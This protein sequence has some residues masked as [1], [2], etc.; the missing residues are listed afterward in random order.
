MGDTK[1]WCSS[2]MPSVPVCPAG[3]GKPEPNLPDI[4]WPRFQMGVQRG[5]SDVLW[6]NLESKSEAKTRVLCGRSFRSKQSPGGTRFFWDGFSQDSSTQ[7]PA[8]WESGG[9]T[10][11]RMCG[12]RSQQRGLV[13][14]EAASQAWQ[15]P[16]V[17]RYASPSL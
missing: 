1:D 4:S 11:T 12:C 14:I 2:H 6:G 3:D 17:P 9:R 8:S 15:S 16:C 10:E 5:H 7:V 13:S